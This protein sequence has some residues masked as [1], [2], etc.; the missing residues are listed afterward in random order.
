MTFRIIVDIIIIILAFV[1]PWWLAMI[2]AAAACFYFSR[3]FEIVFVGFIIDS[4]YN[5]PVRAMAFFQFFTALL[6][7]VILVIAEEVRRRTR[8]QNR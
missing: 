6:G 8:F 5:A 7:L 2:L 4:L 1:A 3:Y